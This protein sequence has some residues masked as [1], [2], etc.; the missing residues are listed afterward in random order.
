[1]WNTLMPSKHIGYERPKSSRIHWFQP[2][3]IAIH[4]NTTSKLR[5]F[6]T[7]G[8]VLGE[9]ATLQANPTAWQGPETVIIET[10]G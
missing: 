2:T 8:I 3:R 9:N 4:A 5:R 7:Y 1:M 6:P 10:A